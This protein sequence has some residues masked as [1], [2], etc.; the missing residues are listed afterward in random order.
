MIND[1]RIE[2]LEIK[3]SYLDESVRILNETVIEKDREID[4][5]KKRMKI[6]ENSLEVLGEE[7]SNEKP[8]HY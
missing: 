5:L 3:F 7:I 6:L 2:E 1:E 8:P 4:S